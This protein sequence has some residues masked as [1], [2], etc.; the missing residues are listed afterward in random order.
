M[1]FALLHQQVTLGLRLLEEQ[2]IF[3]AELLS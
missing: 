3:V 1:A 2:T